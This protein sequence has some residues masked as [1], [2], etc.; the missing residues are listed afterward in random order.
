M[1][2]QKLMD[3]LYSA[4][5]CVLAGLVLV[6]TLLIQNQTALGD[7]QQTRYESY[8]LADELR[9]SSDDLTRLARTYVVTGDSRHEKSYWTALE[10][11]NGKSARADGRT[12]AL[13][14]LMKDAGFMEAELEKLREAE[15]NS[16][17][18]SMNPASFINCWRAILRPSARADVPLRTSS[19]VQ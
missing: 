1:S 18:A 3:S 14:Q 4:G 2:I 9:Q 7:A 10:V 16:N 13:Q 6:T 11:R 12:I 17:S 5:A 15:R 19:V 8:L